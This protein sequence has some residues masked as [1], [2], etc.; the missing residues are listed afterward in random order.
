VTSEPGSASLADEY[1]ARLAARRAA[2]DR[3]DRAHVRYGNV[4]LAIVGIAI[5]LL[6]VMG[7]RGLPWLLLPLGA[8][9][10][11]A[12]AHAR[13]LNARDRASS[14]VR[15]Y[16]RGL[17]RLAHDWIGRGS[18]GDRF[19]IPH[20]PFADDL[21]LFGTGSL[22][23]LLSTARTGAGEETL[24]RWLLEP[25]APDE[26]RARHQAVRELV[27]KLDLR[28]AIAVVGEGSTVGVHAGE[29]R[30]WATSPVRLRGAAIRIALFA[31][32]AITVSTSA[33]WWLEAVP[34]W[35]LLIVIAAQSALALP[36][37]SRVEAIAHGSEA[38]ARDLDLLAD[39]LRILEKEPFASPWLTGLQRRLTG[40]DDRASAEIRRLALRVALL[41]SRENVFFV[42]PAALM[43]WATQFSFAIEAWRDRAGRH[44]PDW[45]DAAGDLEAVIALASFAAEH[46]DY[47]FP[48]LTD[49]PPQVQSTALAHPL[50]PAGAV[51][52]DVTLGSGAPQLLIVSGSNMSGKSTLLRAL[53][54][55]VVLAQAGAPVRASSF[56]LTPLGLGASIRIQ[57]SLQEGHS[58]FFAEITRLK[59]I[60]DL[61]RVRG[62]AA[63]FLL[64][65]ILGG[66]NSHDRRHGAEAL[67]TGLVGL[68]AIGM[69]T[70]HDLAL[71]AIA[72]RLPGQAANVHF[73]DRFDG[74]AL[75]FDY[76]LR[77]GI[78][79]TSNALALMKSIGLDV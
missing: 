68:G 33:L 44:V 46:P 51:A 30:A 24:A 75:S 27:P 45:L 39:V 57:D 42:L 47:A 1:R 5:L 2:L 59:Q 40:G 10:L 74:G 29:L 67:L 78:V 43:L 65:E 28:E 70:T 53:G 62:G 35:V 11:T 36:F 20:H 17:A 71:G 16:E 13:R 61:A 18:P 49:G 22:F 64:D 37:K 55:N 19:R 79:Q 56:R 48:D 38:P 25:A 73:E 76:R 26:I 66:T 34:G 77:A 31:M 8:F 15:F 12:I 4:R 72:E 9:V 60:V 3:H 52:N 6:V 41:V 69:A 50:L 58:R 7:L 32:A 14:A 63:L 23:E 21:D 54:I